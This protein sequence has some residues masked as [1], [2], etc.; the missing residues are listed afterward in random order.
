MHMWAVQVAKRELKRCYYG[1]CGSCRYCELGDS[2]T[3]C[4]ATEFKC[5]R[6]GYHVKADERP[7]NQYE[8][9]R[10]RTNDTI[11]RYDR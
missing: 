8:P 7:C 4:Y 9:D 1:L 11:A 5:S 2:Y 3:S 10:G 6:N